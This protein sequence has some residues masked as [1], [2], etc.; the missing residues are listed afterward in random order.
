MGAA[1]DFAKFLDKYLGEVPA[2]EEG[3]REMRRRLPV[4]FFDTTDDDVRRDSLT[5]DEIDSWTGYMAWNLWELIAKRATEGASGLIPRQEYETIS[6]VQAWATFPKLIRELTKEIGVDGML[7]LGA[8]PRHEIS[9][10]VN[11]TRHF[12]TPMCTL[13]G[14]GIAVNLGLEKATDRREDVETTVQF[15]RRLQHGLWGGGPGFVSGRGFKSACLKPELVSQLLADETRLDDPDLRTAFKKFNAASELFGFLMHYDCR[16]GLCDSGPYDVPGGGFMIVR[17]HQ[18][19]EPAFPWG[20][21]GKGLPW[22]VTQ[23]MVFR[24]AEPVEVKINDIS[25]TFTTPADYHKHL[26]GVAVYARDT[27]DTPMSEVRKLD[28]DELN[29]ITDRVKTA[30]LDL[31]KDIA[32]KDR[33]QKI[34]DGILVYSTILML[35]YART[36]PGLWTHFVENGFYE[37]HEL[38]QAAWPTLAGGDAAA[39]LAPVFILG[40]GFPSVAG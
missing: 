25:T 35:P 30:T 14:R 11:V 2:G 38:T 19:Y 21:M 10:Q 40:Q 28:V 29:A 1:E 36:V 24:P 23:A 8:T 37:L 18:M 16:A 31:Y 34:R 20:N 4:P 15:C 26:S 3:D 5:D 22:S 17:D 12:G 13:V 32:A 9:T 7:K 27:W 6:F 39:A 33:D